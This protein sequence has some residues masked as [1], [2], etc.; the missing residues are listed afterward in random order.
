LRGSQVARQRY[1]A[2]PLSPNTLHAG[3]IAKKVQYL[4]QEIKQ[5]GIEAPC[6]SIGIDSMASRRL[7]LDP[8]SSARTKHIDIIYHH[9]RERERSGEIQFF[10]VSTSENIADIFTKPLLRE[11]FKK[12]RLSLGVML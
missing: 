9:V 2:A 1:L 11:L 4:V 3:E 8:V 12:H 10:S 5:F 7:I 6:V